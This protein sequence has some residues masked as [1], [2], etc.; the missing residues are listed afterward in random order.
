MAKIEFRAINFFPEEIIER[1]KAS[2]AKRGLPLV[3]VPASGHL[4]VVGGGPSIA[5]HKDELRHWDGDVWAING[6][7]EWCRQQGIFA[8]F[9]S[10]D[11]D[12]R[13]A[14]TAAPARHAILGSACDPSVFDAIK[15]GI[16][17]FPIGEWPC[18]STTACVAPFCA[19]QKGYASV[20]LFGCESS[21]VDHVH[22]YPWED[23]TGR[24]LVE[25]GGK[26]YLT[27]PQFI[28][29]AEYLAEIARGIKDYVKT[30]GGGFL[31]ALIEHGDYDVLKISR[32]IAESIYGNRD[33][34]RSEDQSGVM[35]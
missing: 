27:T 35:A 10:I 8:S 16:E 13:L 30:V 31:P 33:L 25:C 19:A 22:A 18:G 7:F 4:A 29:Q 5:S 23:D 21:F 17:V 9:F 34:Q 20:T 3:G 6:A 24:L 15:G 28:M 26:E 32:D 11:P 2:S 14:V 12:P 1:N